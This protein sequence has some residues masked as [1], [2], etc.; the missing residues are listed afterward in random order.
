MYGDWDI[1]SSNTKEEVELRV[2]RYAL[3]AALCPPWAT[4]AVS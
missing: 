4:E 2:L 3:S 1:A